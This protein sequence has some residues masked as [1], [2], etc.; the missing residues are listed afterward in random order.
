MLFILFLW[1]SP[2][3]T[4]RRENYKMEGR[5]LFSEMNGGRLQPTRIRERVKEVDLLLYAA[6]NCFPANFRDYSEDGTATHILRR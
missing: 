3:N 4:R 1:R 5:K 2:T 6:L